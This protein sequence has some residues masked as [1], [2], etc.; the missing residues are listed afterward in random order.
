MGK[1]SQ[2][3]S[4]RPAKS[5]DLAALSR[6]DIAAS[7]THPL[8]AQSFTY[9]FQA[10]KL[11]L[12]HLQ[13]CFARPEE[14]RILVARLRPAPAVESQSSVASALPASGSP[15]VNSDTDSGVDVS[16]ACEFDDGDADSD[17]GRGEI[18]GFVMWREC[19]K[20]S[21]LRED[22]KK[23]EWDWLSQL[24][25][26]A[27]I[28]LWKRYVEV[29]SSDSPTS[30]ENGI[31][32]QKLAVAPRYQRRGI[33]GQL[34][35][36]FIDEVEGRGVKEPVRVRASK[37]AKELYERFGWRMVREFKLDLREWGRYKVYVNF[38]MVRDA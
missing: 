31:E 35:K 2:P 21:D 29:M 3:I 38:E 36:A 16:I 14:Y 25:K 6:L 34:L 27:D 33:G 1:Q 10:L 15:A 30:G 8:I 22:G 12:A 7:A 18:V 32:I 11:F 9:P 26:G 20:N 23:K 24:P 17:D 37:D 5:A 19:Q 28:K 4:I 13:H